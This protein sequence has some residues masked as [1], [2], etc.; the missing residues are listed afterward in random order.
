MQPPQYT[1]PR[2][3]VTSEDHLRRIPLAAMFTALGVLFPQLFHLLGL[4]S[5]FLPMFLPVLTAGM[6]LP[7]RLACTVAVLAPLVSWMLTGMPP[8]SPPVLPL[9][10]AELTAAACLASMFRRKW[11]WPVLSAVAAVMVLDRLLLF[12]IVEAVSSAAGIAHPLLGPGMVLAGLPGVALALLT[13]P[14]AVALI[15][16]QHPRLAMTPGREV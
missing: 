15:E 6:L 3:A 11:R 7:R 1:L 2:P 8:L 4:G 10:L 13:V 16:K 9:L 14:S 12:L 5:A